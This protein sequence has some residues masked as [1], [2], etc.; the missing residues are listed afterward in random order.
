M[1]LMSVNGFTE[2]FNAEIIKNLKDH[3]SAKWIIIQSCQK[4]KNFLLITSI[5][6]QLKSD[7]FITVYDWNDFTEYQNFYESSYVKP[8]V[9]LTCWSCEEDCLLQVARSMQLL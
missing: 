4:F 2:I 5:L 9:L 8:M 3:F 1:C 7:A 6:N